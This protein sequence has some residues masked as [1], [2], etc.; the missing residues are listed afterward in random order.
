MTD[1][2]CKVCKL[3]RTYVLVAVPL[4]LILGAQALNKDASIQSWVPG[5]VLIDLLAYGALGALVAIVGVRF[6][7]EFIDTKRKEKKLNQ[8][9]RRLEEEGAAKKDDR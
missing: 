2:E 9:R 8:V 3:I 5:V 4:V 1:T 6:K 7:K